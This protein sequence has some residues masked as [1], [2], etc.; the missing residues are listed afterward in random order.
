[1]MFVCSFTY[2]FIHMCQSL[3]ASQAWLGFRWISDTQEHEFLFPFSKLSSD[4]TG[5][6]WCFLFPPSPQCLSLLFLFFISLAKK[7]TLLI[8]LH[9]G[10]SLFSLQDVFE[11][12]SPHLL[13]YVSL[14]PLFGGASYV[15][16]SHSAV[17]HFL[18]PG[19]QHT[20]LFDVP[21]PL[22]LYT[23]SVFCTDF[24]L[25][26]STSC[27]LVFPQHPSLRFC[28]F[29][30]ICHSLVEGILSIQLHCYILLIR[31]HT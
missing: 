29:R 20:V 24:L 18:P 25:D 21:S 8:F 26:R 6:F 28:V 9:V 3:Q 7:N 5:V 14:F 16:S 13:T 12:F 22:I 1:M 17:E 11:H 4:L 10:F 27:S 2:S 19:L 31:E 30:S 23:W 15:F